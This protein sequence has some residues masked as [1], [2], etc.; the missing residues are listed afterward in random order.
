MLA[1]AGGLQREDEAALFDGRR[2]CVEHSS[3]MITSTI[4]GLTS[5]LFRRDAR[6]RNSTT[7]V[8]SYP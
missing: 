6:S 8:V 2:F 7:H 3:Q 5:V 4:P 1:G